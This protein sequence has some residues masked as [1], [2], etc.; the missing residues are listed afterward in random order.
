MNLEGWQI[1]MNS[2]KQDKK[3]IMPIF[4]Q[5][6]NMVTNKYSAVTN[7]TENAGKKKDHEKRTSMFGDIVRYIKWRT[8]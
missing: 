8:H 6:R 1:Q 5:I 2:I 7:P 3:V 4:L